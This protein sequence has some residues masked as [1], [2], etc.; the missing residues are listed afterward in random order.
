MA[1]RSRGLQ[2]VVLQAGTRIWTH[3]LNRPSKSQNLFVPPL[4]HLLK[5]P[6]LCLGYDTF[7]DDAAVELPSG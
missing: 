1:H 3:H 6:Y 7:H 5:M 4:W 2:F